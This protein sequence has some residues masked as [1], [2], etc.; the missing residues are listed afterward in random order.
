M[1][2]LMVTHDM[3]LARSFGRVVRLSQGCLEPLPS[4]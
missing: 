4:P 1:T 2:L 3:G